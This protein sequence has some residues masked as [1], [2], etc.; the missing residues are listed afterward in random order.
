[1]LSSS[2]LWKDVSVCERVCKRVCTVLAG[3]CANVCATVR[4]R[5]RTSVRAS[6]SANLV[7]SDGGLELSVGGLDGVL[8]SNKVV[9][10]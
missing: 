1:M 5:V 8:R 10:G 4:N 2:A 3:V 7:S 9:A 6:A